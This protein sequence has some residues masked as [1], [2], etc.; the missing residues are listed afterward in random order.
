[1]PLPKL[2]PFDAVR[3][4]LSNAV[5][6]IIINETDSIFRCVKPRKRVAYDMFLGTIRSTICAT[7]KTYCIGFSLTSSV[8]WYIIHLEKKEVYDKRFS[9]TLHIPR[10]TLPFIGFRQ[11]PMK[12]DR[13]FIGRCGDAVGSDN[14]IPTDRNP[15]TPV[16]NPD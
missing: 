5:S 11:N 15:I 14:R 8:N 13:N 9:R 16:R 3:C 7:S 6:K 10:R 1:V 4:V 2:T 12:F